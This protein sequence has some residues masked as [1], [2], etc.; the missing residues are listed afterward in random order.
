ME[1]DNPR[2]D[3]GVKLSTPPPFHLSP[4]TISFYPNSEFRKAA[5]TTGTLTHPD[6]LAEGFSDK[7]G[8]TKYFFSRTEM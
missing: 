4:F 6:R 1:V 7:K 3:G 8:D 5:G 2:E